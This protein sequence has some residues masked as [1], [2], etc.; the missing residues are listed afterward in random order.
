LILAAILHLV[1]LVALTVVVHWINDLHNFVVPIN[2]FVLSQA[3][4][5]QFKI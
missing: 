2:V 1:M 4:I 5:N 3:T